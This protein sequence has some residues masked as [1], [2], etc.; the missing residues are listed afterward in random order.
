MMKEEELDK[1]QKKM[2]KQW[3]EGLVIIPVTFK[4]Y[5]VVSDDWK[6]VE[7]QKPPEGKLVL[8]WIEYEENGNVCQTYGFG[9][10]DGDGWIIYLQQCEKVL[11]WNDLPEPYKTIN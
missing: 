6:A 10:W 2:L 8:V 9:R 7:K 4:E 5:E 3:N 11:A 1:I